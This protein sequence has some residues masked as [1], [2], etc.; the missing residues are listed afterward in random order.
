MLSH[1]CIYSVFSYDLLRNVF[2]YGSR[3]IWARARDALSLS[4]ANTALLQNQ[5]YCIS[6]T[7]LITGEI[8]VIFAHDFASIYLLNN[9]EK[10]KTNFRQSDTDLITRITV[11]MRF[12]REENVTSPLHPR[13]RGQP[14]IFQKTAT[15]L[16]RTARRG[17]PRASRGN[18][19]AGGFLPTVLDDR[20]RPCHATRFMRRLF[21]ASLSL[22]GNRKYA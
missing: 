21:I 5:R 13:A 17:Q 9:I 6:S 22:S 8:N 4:R 11:Y 14:R 3:F 7:L 18:N 20:I 10:K 2:W 12:C 1:L 15:R 19:S 16:L